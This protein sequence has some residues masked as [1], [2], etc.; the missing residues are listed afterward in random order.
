MDEHTLDLSG[1]ETYAIFPSEEYP[2]TAQQAF[3]QA[4]VDVLLDMYDNLSTLEVGAVGTLESGVD[5][6]SISISQSAD[7]LNWDAIE[8]YDIEVARRMSIGFGHYHHESQLVF[9]M[10]LSKA[11]VAEQFGSFQE[12]MDAFKEPIQTALNRMGVDASPPEQGESFPGLDDNIACLAGNMNRY[13]DLAVDG[14]KIS[15]S[16]MHLE[17]PHAVLVHGT[18][19][20]ERELDKVIEVFNLDTTVEEFQKNVTSISRE[21]DIEREEANT[22]LKE[23]L[24]DWAHTQENTGVV[25]DAVVERAEELEAEKYGTEEW[26]MER[27]ERTS[28]WSDFQ[29]LLDE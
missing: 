26:I 22:I 23:T 7:D 29:G 4:M 14:R 10:G 24:M 18:I 19:E 8:K 3:Q 5:A 13:S 6:A 12:T 1:T 2:I 15:T 21:T 11:L 27:Q 20:Y 9:A 25:R 28:K 17:F 16:I